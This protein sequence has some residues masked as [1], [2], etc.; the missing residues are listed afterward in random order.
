MDSDQPSSPL[1]LLAGATG[2][3]GF[4]IAQHLLSEGVRLRVL[5]RGQSPHGYR[6]DA[7]RSAGADVRVL[8]FDYIP[9]VAQACAGG[10]CLVS[11]VSGLEDVIVGLQGKLLTAA[12]EAGVPRFMPSD[13]CI[14]YTKLKPGS[15]RNLD[16][17]RRF[18]EIIDASPIRATG[19]LN[20]MFTELLQDEA[21]LLQR[22]IRRVVYWGNAAQPMDFTTRA[23]TAAYTAR[24]ALDPTTPRYLRIAGDVQSINGLVNAATEVYGTRFEKLWLGNLSVLRGMISMTRFLTGEGDAIFPPWQGM[25]YLHDMLSG[26]VKLH[27]LDNDRYLVR[28]KSVAQVLARKSPEIKS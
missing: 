14:D 5:A 22:G 24:A 23:D 18:A 1:I 17:R 19:I 20:G 16:L 12:L 13:F 2:D 27:P 6:L 7:F 28:W 26:D 11:A 9:A 21:P 15:N 8:N 3:L 10:S 25:Q 4:R